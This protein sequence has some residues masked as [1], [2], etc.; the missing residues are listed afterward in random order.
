MEPQLDRPI[1]LLLTTGGGSRSALWRQIVAD[2]TG[3]TVVACREAET[4]SL[5]AGM[6]AAA[7]AGWYGSVREAAEAMSGVGARQ[8]PDPTAATRYDDLFAIYREIYPRTAPL[9]QALQRATDDH[10]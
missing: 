3:K 9:H 7:A 1:E 5:G 10:V 6:Q 8:T 2:V 4:T